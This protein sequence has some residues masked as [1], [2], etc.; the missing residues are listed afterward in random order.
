LYSRT[1]NSLHML[2]HKLDQRRSSL[3]LA[4]RKAMSPKSKVE[5]R[6]SVSWGKLL[7]SFSSF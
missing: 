5:R 6:R 3:I 1:H 2:F 4:N 7:F